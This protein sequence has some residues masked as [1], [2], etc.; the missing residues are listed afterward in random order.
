[1]SRVPASVPPRLSF[2][3]PARIAHAWR[4]FPRFVY[5]SVFSPFLE[6][7]RVLHQAQ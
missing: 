1:M 4:I 5:S 3:L 6:C 7:G 2:A